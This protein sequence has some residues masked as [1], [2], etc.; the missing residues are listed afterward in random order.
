VWCFAE[1]FLGYYF[2]VR[3]ELSS[4]ATGLLLLILLFLGAAGDAVAAWLLRKV[5]GDRDAALRLQRRGA[6]ITA[7]AFALLFTRWSAA[8][9][10]ESFLWALSCG[11]GFRLAFAFYAI[12]QVALLSLLPGDKADV[13]AFVALNS[14]MGALARL[15]TAVATF[16]IAGGLPQVTEVQAQFYAYLLGLLVIAV[17]F[18]LERTFAGALP[19]SPIE[20]P[21]QADIG[22]DTGLHM[23]PI[24]FGWL[25]TC[26]GV[27]AAALFMVSRLFLFTGNLAGSS[28]AGPWLMLCSSAG[29]AAGPILGMLMTRHVRVTTAFSLTTGG[30]AV[31]AVMLSFASVP[32]G[33]RIPASALYGMFLGASG[34]LLWLSATQRVREYARAT[35]RRADWVAF[36]SIS[37]VIKIGVAAG[38][39]LLAFFIDGYAAG[40]PLQSLWLAVLSA[41]GALICVLAWRRSLSSLSYSR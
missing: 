19:N 33:A 36:G 37:V 25:L 28:A 24:G 31:M 12:P 29:I 11:T 26:F 10:R 4:G 6:L 8:T 40:N 39:G 13:R 32:T 17:S 2:R 35:R 23:L 21:Q 27:H 7:I 41:G 5:G 38:N 16:L 1:L 9:Q 20:L 15:T 22:P 18:S 14:T 34:M 3:L 30:T